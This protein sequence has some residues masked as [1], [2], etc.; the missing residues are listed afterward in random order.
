MR[1]KNWQIRFILPNLKAGNDFETEYV[2]IVEFEDERVQKIIR[3]NAYIAAILNGFIDDFRNKINPSILIVDIN[4]PLQ[5]RNIECLVNFRNI[6]AIS[7]ILLN[8]S[9]LNPYNVFGPLFSDSFDFYPISIN[10]DGSSVIET[11]ALTSLRSKESPFIATSIP[12]VPEFNMNILYDKQV[13]NGLLKIWNL[14]YSG[15]NKHSKMINKVFRS[16]EVAYHALSIPKKNQSSINDIGINICL[17]IS[18]LEILA[19]PKVKK[20]QITDVL[21]LL[22]S[23]PDFPTELNKKKYII[24]YSKKGQA[25]KA[26][27]IEKLYKKLYDSRNIFLHGNNIP[28][29][30][31]KTFYRKVNYQHNN[32]SNVAP[33]LYRIALYSYLFQTKI[34]KKRTYK[35]YLDYFAN[36]NGVVNNNYNE[37]LIK[38]RK[39]QKEDD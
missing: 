6:I 27:L 31:L 21:N 12:G 25:V 28:P 34:I 11:P 5:Y 8:W 22:N 2:S 32:I 39:S 20:V 23:Y 37:F 29:G 30:I 36:S 24:R 1:E 9:N 13:Y 15:N 38:I 35:S 3:E 33:I 4:A 10:L 7:V 14:K 26:T 16:I 18:A 19:H 17:W